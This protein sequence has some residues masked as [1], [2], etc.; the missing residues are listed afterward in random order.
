[1]TSDQPYE[2][3]DGLTMTARRALAEEIR[4]LAQPSGEFGAYGSFIGRHGIAVHTDGDAGN[5]GLVDPRDLLRALADDLEL[6][7]LPPEP[8]E[9]TVMRSRNRRHLWMR[10]SDIDDGYGAELRVTF[11]WANRRWWSTA[12]G[13]PSS[14]LNVHGLGLRAGGVS[15]EERPDPDAVVFT[16]AAPAEAPGG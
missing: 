14:W 4:E 16:G 10:R 12:G 1:M 9:G 13:G 8:P 11:P 15:P 3:T 7:G 2:G 6:R 5:G